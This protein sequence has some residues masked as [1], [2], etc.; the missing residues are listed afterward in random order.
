MVVILLI[1]L[2]LF[3]GWWGAKILKRKL[4][5]LL[6]LQWDGIDEFFGRVAIFFG[7]ITILCATAHYIVSKRRLEK[8]G[9][10]WS[11]F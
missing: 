1:T 7:P 6:A 10:F 8:K 3:T 2:W 9:K 5:P 4:F 11:W